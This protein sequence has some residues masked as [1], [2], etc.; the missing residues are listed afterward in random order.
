[1]Y[2]IW[3]GHRENILG[4][5]G[6]TEGQWYVRAVRWMSVHYEIPLALALG[7]LAMIVILKRVMA[8]RE[9]LK[10]DGILRAW[11]LLLA[12]FSIAGAVV[13]LAEAAQ[14]RLDKG[15]TLAQDLC[16]T[17]EWTANPFLLLFCLSKIPE[18][19]D[20]VFLLLRKRPV[21]LLHWYHHFATMLYC[22]D[23][24]TLAIATAAWFGILNLVVH[25]IM[26]SYYFAMTFAPVRARIPR[27]VAP[28]IT[29]LQIVQ[30]VAG[31]LIIVFAFYNCPTTFLA[32]DARVHANLLAGIVMYLSYLVL[33]SWLF[34]ERY[35]FP[36]KPT[37]AENEK[38]AASSKPNSSP[39]PTSK[40]PTPKVD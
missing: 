18:L 24:M 14:L 33:F 28:L 5:F 15:Y 17:N 23:A 29:A 20:T 27:S 36:S 12:V 16:L 25:S 31:L 8:N 35:I 22:W 34:L 13:M 39:T 6:A 2:E 4:S 38:S 40:K 32:P 30:M 7:Y 9:A 21:I 19:V 26:Y 11:N 10:L 37:P 1:M 3:L